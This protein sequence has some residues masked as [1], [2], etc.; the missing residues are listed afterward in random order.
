MTSK[1]ESMHNKMAV[2]NLM[3][4]PEQKPY[5]SFGSKI[6]FATTSQQPTTPVLKTAYQILPSTSGVL[7]PPISPEQR[8]LLLASQRHIEGIGAGVSLTIK[9]PILYP[10]SEASSISQPPLFLDQ[11][12][13]SIISSDDVA[14]IE[15]H[16]SER[17]RQ[18]YTWKRLNDTSPPPLPNR[19][20][21]VA[22][23][24]FKA[25]LMERVSRDPIGHLNR[26]RQYLKDQERARNAYR[27]NLI[28]TSKTGN[29][30][31]TPHLKKKA[32]PILAPSPSGVQKQRASPKTPARAPKPKPRRERSRTSATPD[33]GSGRSRNTGT[34]TREDKD[35]R[36]LRDRCPPISTLDVLVAS[37]VKDPLHADWK[38]NSLDISK[39][40]LS[41]LLHPQELVLASRL[42]LD[43][44]TY[45]TSKRRIFLARYECFKGTWG[46]GKGKKEFR[47]TD[48]QQACKIDVNKAS[49]L[50]VS[51]HN[52]GWFD[53]KWAKNQTD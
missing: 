51:F 31:S 42:R 45:L 12:A 39:D 21:Y 24:E 9:D 4:P 33:I 6:E 7:S 8:S 43:C 37:G 25:C 3:S 46:Q 13:L 28:T 41:G 36:A 48:A 19:D 10:H 38:G 16:M 1:M 30:T 14:Q 29:V 49:K 35:F 23:L 52:A 32:L 15:R 53:E 44:A 20:E 11:Q 40:P 5:E 27:S 22:A 34:S 26:E 50:W 2:G 47:K 18:K 17:A